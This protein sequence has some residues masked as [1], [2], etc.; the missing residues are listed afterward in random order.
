MLNQILRFLLD[1]VFGFFV[2]VL[3]AR[4]YLQLLRAPFRNP[5]G[6][7]VTALTNWLVLPAR[8][9]IPGMFGL[10]MASFLLAWLLEALLLFLLYF[11]RGGS[12]VG[13]SGLAVGIFFSLGLLEL[14]RFSLYL[15]IG[16]ILIQAVISWINPYAPLAPLFNTLTGPFL[17]PFRRL[18]PPIGNVDLSPLFAL[19]AAQLLLIPLEYVA[20]SVSLLL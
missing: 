10:D 4:F 13:T 15:L 11:L 19:V 5:L 8:R 7:F 3:L 12:V 18:I 17:R 6:Q 20:R 14:A 2:F 1:T 9:F 16:V